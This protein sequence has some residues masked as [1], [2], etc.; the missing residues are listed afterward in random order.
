MT[1][2]FSV[3]KFIHMKHELRYFTTTRLAKIAKLDNT[4]WN[5]MWR[6]QFSYRAEGKAPWCNTITL[7]TVVFP[8]HGTHTNPVTRSF[9]PRYAC[10]LEKLCKYTWPYRTILKFLLLFKFYPL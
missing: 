3:V 5:K 4:H 1:L 10:A 2:V 6:S 7:K 8:I 9:I